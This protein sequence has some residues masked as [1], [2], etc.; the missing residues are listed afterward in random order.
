MPFPSVFTKLISFD[1]ILIQTF[2]MGDLF[3]DFVN[4]EKTVE[5][6]RNIADKRFFTN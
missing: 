4:V 1:K 5:F 3:L 6:K 2:F